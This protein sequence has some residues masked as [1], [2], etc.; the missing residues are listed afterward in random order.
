MYWKYCFCIVNSFPGSQTERSLSHYFILFT[1]DARYCML[2]QSYHLSRHNGTLPCYCLF[3][4]SHCGLLQIG[5]TR[6]LHPSNRN[7]IRWWD[8][9]R[10]VSWQ[11][12]L[13]LPQWE[14]IWRNLGLRNIYRGTITKSLLL[15]EDENSYGHKYVRRRSEGFTYCWKDPC[16]ILELTQCCRV[17]AMFC[18]QPLLLFFPME[19]KLSSWM[20]T[21]I[22]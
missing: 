14:Q 21:G 7:Q 17:G 1:R 16:S 5:G 2:L 8:E 18:F 6:H 4:S 20:R 10:N 9:R 13:A 19:I 22:L 3:P 11:G 15:I 12:H